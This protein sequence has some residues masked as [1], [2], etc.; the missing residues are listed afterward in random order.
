[1]KTTE[2][3]KDET[4]TWFE[5]RATKKLLVDR[6]YNE[7]VIVE[8]GEVV[9]MTRTPEK[10]DKYQYGFDGGRAFALYP[11]KFIKIFKVTERTVKEVAV[12]KV[13]KKIGGIKRFVNVEITTRCIEREEEAV[14]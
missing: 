10:R 4:L 2:I 7:D 12:E 3:K 1:M 11:A 13:T 6:F 8:K 5:H 14:A 9:E